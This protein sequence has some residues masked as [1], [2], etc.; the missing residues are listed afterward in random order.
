MILIFG[1]GRRDVA[2]GFNP[3]TMVEPVDPFERGVLD[4][5]KVVPRPTPVDH[6][7]FVQTVDSLG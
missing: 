6:L 2:D 5:F 7:D 1:F 4:G 3:P